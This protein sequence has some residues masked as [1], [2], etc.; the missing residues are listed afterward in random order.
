MMRAAIQA[1]RCGEPACVIS[2]AIIPST[3]ESVQ[4]VPDFT[5]APSACRASGLLETALVSS[6]NTHSPKGLAGRLPKLA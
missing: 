3:P 2:V 6:K 4:N 1:E 5:N